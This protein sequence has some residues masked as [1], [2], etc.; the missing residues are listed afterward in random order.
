MLDDQFNK[1]IVLLNKKK[2]CLSA[3]AKSNKFLKEML[4]LNVLC[5]ESIKK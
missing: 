4:A 3:N 5:F 2:V 1:K